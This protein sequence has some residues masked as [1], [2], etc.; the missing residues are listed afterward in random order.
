M[1]IPGLVCLLVALAAVER[2]GR[3]AG[4]RSRLPWRR[5]EGGADLAVSAVALDVFGTAF[6]PGREQEIAQRHSQSLLRTDDAQGGP[7]R[8]RVDLDTGRVWLRPADADRPT[9]P[10]LG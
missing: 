2:L 7:P 4:Q 6:Q 3:R 10:G 8:S 5:G 1:T 9:R